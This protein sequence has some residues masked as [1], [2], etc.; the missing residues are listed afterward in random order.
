[1]T[2]DT[3]KTAKA[4]VGAIFIAMP[5]SVILAVSGNIVYSSGIATSISLIAVFGAFLEIIGFLGIAASAY[6]LLK[7]T[8][9][10]K[11]LK[12]KESRLA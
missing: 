6:I 9:D 7:S 5:M 11:D 3:S 8:K 10:Q 12:N 1:M 2:T 4:V